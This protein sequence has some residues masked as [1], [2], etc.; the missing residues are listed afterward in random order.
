MGVFNLNNSL[1]NKIDI[2]QEV[3]WNDVVFE[4]P[5]FKTSHIAPDFSTDFRGV[6][7]GKT[8]VLPRYCGYT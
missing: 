7:I 3:T 6:V 8:V 5:F 4:N 1:M 2:V